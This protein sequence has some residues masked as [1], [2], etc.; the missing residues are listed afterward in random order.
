MRVE[1]E[2]VVVIERHRVD[3]D[4]GGFPFIAFETSAGE[5]TLAPFTATIRQHSSAPVVL[6]GAGFSIFP[7]QLLALIAERL[8]A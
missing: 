5:W 8:H 1:D 4:P 2:D 3:S 6:G 7:E